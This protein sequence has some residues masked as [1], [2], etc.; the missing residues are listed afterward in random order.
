MAMVSL[1]LSL[2]TH[3]HTLKYVMV[4]KGGAKYEAEWE[5]IYIIYGSIIPF[6]NF[7]AVHFSYV[8]Q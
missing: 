2:Y 7:T 1:S 4:K 5:L 3:T 6:H 8:L